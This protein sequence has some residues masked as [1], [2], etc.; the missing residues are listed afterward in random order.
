MACGYTYIRS[1]IYPTKSCCKNIVAYNYNYNYAVKEDK[2][3]AQQPLLLHGILF[4]ILSGGYL[5]AK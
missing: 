5:M 2:N 1:Y 3:Y 4:D